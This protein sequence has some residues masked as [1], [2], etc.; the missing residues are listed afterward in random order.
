MDPDLRTGMTKGM[1]KLILAS[2]SKQRIALM[3][4]LN[5]PLIVIPADI[6]EKAIRD[7]DPAKQAEKI[8]RAKAERVFAKHPEAVIVAG[9]SFA[10]VNGKVFEKPETKEEA[11]VMLQEQSGQKGIVYAGICYIDPGKKMNI[12]K[13]I[14]IPFQFR[15]FTAEEISGYVKKFPSLTWSGGISPAYIYGMTMTQWLN[16]SLTGFAH[17]FPMETIIPLLQR[18]G[19][20]ITP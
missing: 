9:D 20:S 3:E 14:E 10:V 19:F 8:A 7:S 18:S 13:T 15:E 6:D 4:A 16:G 17:G 11:K 2:S 5:L 12:S 1:K